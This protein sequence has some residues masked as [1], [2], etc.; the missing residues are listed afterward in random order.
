MKFVLSFSGGK[1]SILALH[2]MVEAGHEPVALLVMYLEDARRS[3]VHG[4]DDEMLHALSDALRI[5]LLRCAARGETYASDMEQALLQA[6]ELGA[7]ACA[8]GDIDITEHRT[9]DEER[10]KAVGLTPALPLWG[11][12]RA[13]NVRDAIALG[14]RCIIKC[15]RSG[16]LPETL[17]GQPLNE[18]VLDEMEKY[19]VDLCGENGEYHTI[20][21]DGPLFRHP[22]EIENQGT[23]HLE[24]VTATDL[25]LKK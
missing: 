21:V 19:G 1:D 7:Q 22:I 23:V 8:F 14:Y 6:K 11:R 4:I 10:C 3:W 5:P 16:I 25:V 18:E 2:R 24:Y 17:L 15:V 9:W 20:V 13:E 12:N